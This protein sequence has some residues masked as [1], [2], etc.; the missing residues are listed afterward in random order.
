MNGVNR[1]II[2]IL[3]LIAIVLCS[4]SLVLPLPVLDAV[5]QQSDALLEF[6][7]SLQ[8][9]A[10]VGLGILFAVAL[11]IVLILLIVLEVRRPKPKAIRIENASGGEVQISIASI[12]DRLRYEVDQLS[13]ILHVKP[14]VS[15]KRKGVVIEL[16]VETAAGTQVP[17]KAEQVMRAARQVV[18]ERMGLKLA[19]PPKVNM[20]AVPYP[21][22][23][24][25]STRARVKEE[26]PI[27]SYPD[28]PQEE[29]P[30]LP[31]D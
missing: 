7:D 23:P 8:W 11:D 13:G 5:A 20:H 1:A 19:R 12:T 27:A 4:V 28:A 14:Q 26:P 21:K 18:E 6:L 29:L 15:A 16:D 10:R 9:Y 31:E 2:V 17:E 3:L 25:S 24:K 22:T 30:T